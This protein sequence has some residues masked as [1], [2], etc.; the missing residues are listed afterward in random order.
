MLLRSGTCSR[1]LPYEVRCDRDKRGK[2]KLRSNPVTDIEDRGGCCPVTVGKPLELHRP[3]I[4]EHNPSGIQSTRNDRDSDTKQAIVSRTTDKDKN[5]SH[6]KRQ[7]NQNRNKETTLH[8]L[9]SQVVGFAENK[10]GGHVD[11]PSLAKSWQGVRVGLV[12]GSFDG[13]CGD[14]LPCG[15]DR[16]HDSGWAAAWGGAPQ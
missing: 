3:K 5:K 1:T 6:Q 15:A 7:Q 4:I 14:D 9:R 8:K 2:E 16:W 12:Y 10:R 11:E 13:E